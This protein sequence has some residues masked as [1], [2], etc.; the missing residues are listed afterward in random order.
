MNRSVS[1]HLHRFASGLL[2]L[3]ILPV[4]LLGAAPSASQAA[5]PERPRLQTSVSEPILGQPVYPAVFEGDLRSLPQETGEI[6]PGELPLYSLPLDAGAE[7]PSALDADPVL[8]ETSVS[9]VD[10]PSPDITFA[11]LDLTNFGAGWPPDTNG[12]VGPDHFIQAVNTSIGIFDKAT[13]V[14]LAGFSFNAFFEGTGTPCDASNQGDVVVLYDHM[15]DRWIITDFAWTDRANGPYYECIAVSRSAD[16]LSGGWY[17]Y[18]LL[19]DSAWLHDY[20]KL[21]VW[22]DAYYMSA[23]MFDLN[24]SGGGTF[25]GVGVWALDRASMLAGGALNNVKFLLSTAYFSLLP[26]NL[27]GPIPPPGSPNYFT[28]VVDSTT[29]LLRVWEFQV[30]WAMPA[31]STFTNTANLAVASFSSALSCGGSGR[32]CIPQSG[33]AQMLDAIAPRLM[34]QAQYRNFG[35]YE[36]LW[37]NHTVEV[38]TANDIAG[39]RWYELRDPG[40]APTIYQQGSY[41]STGAGAVERWMGSL[42]ADRYNNMALGYSASNAAMFPAI[43]YAGRLATDTLGTLPQAEATMYAGTGSQTTYNRWGDYSTMSVDPVDDC[44]FWYTNEYYAATGTNWQTRIGSFR[45][46]TCASGKHWIGGTSTSWNDP[47][48]WSPVGVPTRYDDVLIDA[49]PAPA[50]WPSV[51]VDAQVH[52]MT[53]DTGG[54]LNATANFTLSIYGDWS[55][56]GSA[57]FNAITGTVVLLD[58]SPSLNM[59]T[60]GSGNHFYNLQLGDGVRTP[61]VTLAGDL[62]ADG[63]LSVLPG[64]SFYPGSNTVE[65]GG[66]LDI[67]GGIDPGASTVR[68][69]GAGAHNLSVAPQTPTQTLLSENFESWPLSGW[70]IVN[71]GG[72]CVWRAGSAEAIPDSNTTG[73]AGDYADADSDACG[74]GTSI[75]SDLRSPVL[76]LSGATTALLQFK[77]DMRRYLNDQWDVDLSLDGGATWPT[78]LLHRQGSSYRGPETILLDLSSALGQSNVRLRFR[79]RGSW[80]YWWQVDEV[81]VTAEL[82]AAHLYNLEVAGS[83]P[84]LLGADLRLENNLQVAAGAIFDLST[85]SLTLDGS[86]V[87]NGMLRQSVADLNDYTRFMHITDSAGAVDKYFGV[88]VTPS[89]SMGATTVEIRGNQA[90]CDQNNELIHR[91]FDLAPG[92]PQIAIVRF[93]YLNSERGA[94]E[95]SLMQAYHWANPG[96]VALTLN[97]P[98]RG[99][100]GAYEWV[101]AMGVADYSP[102]GLSDGSPSTPTAIR[103][104]RFAGRQQ[105][106]PIAHFLLGGIL[107][108]VV[109]IYAA[110]SRAA[111]S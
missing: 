89:A 59:G 18:G 12:D 55:Q 52:K 28:S 38:D 101:E 66:D 29:D 16:P 96:W 78:N 71:N 77:S 27:R 24:A 87:N 106:T 98:P 74:S 7:A 64:A 57:S 111:R 83:G 46:P 62:R 35:T 17:Q 86:L 99:T 43:R 2:G 75:D 42:A 19:A 67:Q 41:G 33:T 82:P 44:T 14:R 32:D 76:D 85:H 70:G 31:S 5:P 39:I 21:G 72:N 51:D 81:R 95:V 25:Q 63:S 73:G 97:T 69:I 93:W 47:A 40:G 20:P 100:L 107:L 9:L 49:V 50:Y 23:N 68:F 30:N 79:Y 34:M 1:V 94:E 110:K 36:S 11:G 48:N 92:A 56:I 54:Q 22:P 58:S 13:G 37:L 102:F 104:V 26:G 45:Y 6:S 65:V 15:A 109:L 8:Q 10:M 91:C 80:D 3:A 105:G 60:P 61:A 108:A 84:V 53:I 88:D 90:A 4:L 103:L